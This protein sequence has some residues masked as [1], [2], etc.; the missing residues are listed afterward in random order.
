M[1]EFFFEKHRIDKVTS[2]RR[3]SS[4]KKKKKKMLGFK[5]FLRDR[6]LCRKVGSNFSIC[7]VQFEP[8]RFD[9]K[10][11][12]QSRCTEI[13]NAWNSLDPIIVEIYVGFENTKKVGISS[14]ISSENA[15][16]VDFSKT[17]FLYI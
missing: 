13:S 1:T 4:I 12:L 10:S 3:F 7:L 2:L 16:F 17:F 9:T 6:N 14:D 11:H 15:Y 8:T 5:E